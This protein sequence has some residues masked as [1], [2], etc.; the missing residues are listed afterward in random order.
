M[1]EKTLTNQLNVKD[2]TTNEGHPLDSR[3]KVSSLD[4]LA[5]MSG[6]YVGLHIYVE[7]R[8][9]EYVVTKLNGT[10]IDMEQGLVTLE[11]FVNS[12]P[13]AVLYTAQTLTNNQKAQARQNIG[14]GTGDYT[15]LVNKPIIPVKVSD[16][17]NDSGFITIENMSTKQDTLVSGTNIKTI[18]N[19]SILGSGNITIQGGSGGTSDYSQLSNKPSINGVELS[20]NKTNSQLG[21]PTKTSDLTNDSGFLT[22]ESEPAFNSSVAK[23][24]SSA[25][26]SN[27]NDKVDKTSEINQIYGTNNTGEQFTRLLSAGA[28]A[29]T[30]PIRGGGGVLAVGTP[31]ADAHAT[32]KKYVDDN[33]ATKQ[34]TLVS[35]TN[36]KTINNQSILGSGNITIEGGSGGTTTKQIVFNDFVKGGLIND[37]SGNMRSMYPLNADEV[38]GIVCYTNEVRIG[39]Y[40]E[41]WTE[42][43]NT[44]VSADTI[45]TNPQATNS[46]YIMLSTAGNTII[47]VSIIVDSSVDLV[48]LSDVKF[49]GS[50]LFTLFSTKNI[51]P[52]PNYLNGS[53]TIWGTTRPAGVCEWVSGGVADTFGKALHVSKTGNIDWMGKT[54]NN[55]YKP[56]LTAGHNYLFA[57]RG[58]LTNLV[59]Q[60]TENGIYEQAGLDALYLAKSVRNTI[61][62]LTDDYVSVIDTINPTTTGPQAITLGITYSKNRNVGTIEGY[63]GR[64][65]IV[66]L[67]SLN[68]IPSVRELQWIYQIFIMTLKAK[69]SKE[70][71]ALVENIN[72]TNIFI[73]SGQARR[74]YLNEA[75]KILD[76]IGV[77]NYNYSNPSGTNNSAS[78]NGSQNYNKINC[79]GM[80]KAALQ[81]IGHPDLLRMLAQRSMTLHAMRGK[82]VVNIPVT[83][84][85][86]G[87]SEHTL[88]WTETV[89]GEIQYHVSYNNDAS[90]KALNE[91]YQII[92]GKGGNWGSNLTDPSGM[93]G[94]TSTA[95]YL[96]RSNKYKGKAMIG[97]LHYPSYKDFNVYNDMINVFDNLEGVEEAT[98]P[99]AIYA[100]AGYVP[101]FPTSCKYIDL[102]EYKK[103][104][105]TAVFNTASMIK[106][107]SATVI[108]SWL[109]KGDL[110]E[111]TPDCVVGGSA[112]NYQSDPALGIRKQVGDKFVYEEIMPAAMM[113]S[114][115]EMFFAMA[116]AAGKKMVLSRMDNPK[117]D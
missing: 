30:I 95:V 72:L 13:N 101:D 61:T 117:I 39:V 76:E 86:M 71:Q 93:A 92:M 104:D 23:D 62:E 18:N 50:D 73:P 24:I 52:D 33:L 31:T 29:S 87:G 10:D 16:L 55:A 21:I 44:V 65:D 94:N 98:T 96:C 110:I 17:E 37:N 68:R 56:S 43:S 100:A 80:A 9:T 7:D 6:A 1:K 41:D 3:S 64:Y 53:S 38:K 113:A 47:P 111:Y 97:V 36:I 27:W 25:D 2:N 4:D 26:I 106:F 48:L 42:I 51:A 46:R 79:D 45:W 91:A 35:G 20:G 75:R 107:F 14:A 116:T 59:K 114:D 102:L 32:T 81:M 22:S 34:D 108:D 63:I 82:S 105:E 5:L 74:L 109:K 58:K 15:D 28:T 89:G 77:S 8:Q 115:N 103:G 112:I 90:S 60:S 66:D 19:Q 84:N 88:Y 85:Y 78:V 67:T 99:S 49:C 57:W 40:G 11:E 12:N 69:P 70:I 83:A 54:W